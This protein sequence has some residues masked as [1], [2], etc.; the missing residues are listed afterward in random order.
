MSNWRNLHIPLSIITV[1]ALFNR[2]HTPDPQPEKSP[3]LRIKV[4]QHRSIHF[5]RLLRIVLFAR[6]N[7]Q[8][9]SVVVHVFGDIEKVLIS[10]RVCMFVAE[11]E[12]CEVI[13]VLFVEF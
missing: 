7:S 5:V 1:L 2:G 11:T 9:Y 6:W 4:K 12:D 8:Q 10:V 3:K 13:T